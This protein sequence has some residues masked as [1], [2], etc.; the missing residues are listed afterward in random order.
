[1]AEPVANDFAAISAAILRF[2]YDRYGCYLRKSLPSVECWCHRAGA[3][4]QKL[5]CPPAEEAPAPNG[6]GSV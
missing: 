5:P 3:D 2:K 4:G 6:W 1:M